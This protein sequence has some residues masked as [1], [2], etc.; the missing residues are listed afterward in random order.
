MTFTYKTGEHPEGESKYKKTQGSAQ[1]STGKHFNKMNEIKSRLNALRMGVPL[2]QFKRLE[3]VSCCPQPVSTHCGRFS[4]ESLAS[5][6][7]H[8][9]REYLFSN[10]RQAMYKVFPCDDKCEC[11]SVWFFLL[12]LLTTTTLFMSLW[13][14][15]AFPCR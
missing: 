3:E 12:I 7:N 13:F 14:L 1:Y 4:L 10:N 11:K 5:M 2:F 8:P 6:Y 15:S 9:W